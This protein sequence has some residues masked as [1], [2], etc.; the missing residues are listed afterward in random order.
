VTVTTIQTG[1]SQPIYRVSRN[2]V[3]WVVENQNWNILPVDLR[4]T[5]RQAVSPP[6]AMA[7][8]SAPAVGQQ[9]Q[10]QQQELQQLRQEIAD[11]KRLIQQSQ[12]P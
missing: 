11:L 3:A 8:S 2:G 12:I 7:A 6:G 10:Q 9:L 1:Q 5:V 4:D